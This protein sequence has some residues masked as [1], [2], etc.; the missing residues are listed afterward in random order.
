MKKQKLLEEY[1]IK[2]IREKAL[3]LIRKWETELK[4]NTN[5]NKK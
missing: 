3:E 4:E 5:I 1:K 2:E